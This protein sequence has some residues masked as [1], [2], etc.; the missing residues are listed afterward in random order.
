VRI[1]LPVQKVAVGSMS[2]RV[3]QDGCAAVRRG[4]QA[5]DLRPHL[6]GAV[7][8]VTSPVVQGDMESHEL[9]ATAE[10]PT[11]VS[12]DCPCCEAALATATATAT[13]MALA[14]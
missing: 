3:A 8:F 5:Y 2:K 13:A 7:V 11:S 6:H 9:A 12:C 10:T 14:S 4:P 1:L